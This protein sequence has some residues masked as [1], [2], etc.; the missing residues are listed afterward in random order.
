MAMNPEVKAKWV[1]ALRSGRFKQGR[2][3]LRDCEDNF[4][5]L[6]V[7]CEIAA[8]EHITARSQSHPND[9][10]RYGVEGSHRSL[11]FLPFEVIRWS[12][13]GAVNPTVQ[14]NGETKSLIDLNDGLALPFP[15][16]ADLIE[17]QL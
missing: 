9:A 7:L 3:A 12:G 13:L 14:Y 11:F 6:G 1:A 2:E 4:C 17:A 15:Q 16:I 5:C 8:E 10:Y